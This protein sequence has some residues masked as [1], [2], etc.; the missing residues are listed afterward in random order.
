MAKLRTAPEQ[1]AY[2]RRMR[3]LHEQLRQKGDPFASEGAGVSRES[4]STQHP[5]RRSHQTIRR[6]LAQ[7]AL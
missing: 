5:A 1:Q 4:T 3:L 2:E 6:T 7:G